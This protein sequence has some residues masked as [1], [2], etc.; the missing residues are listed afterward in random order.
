MGAQGEIEVAPP[1]PNKSHGAT[2]VAPGATSIFACAPIVL[3]ND[4]TCLQTTRLRQV[5]RTHGEAPF[6]K[7]ISG[8]KLQH[9][10]LEAQ[11]GKPPPAA[12]TFVQRRALFRSSI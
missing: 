7:R 10:R 3:L 2:F 12:K 4:A 11:V 8:L 9:T 6:K 5:P 1:R